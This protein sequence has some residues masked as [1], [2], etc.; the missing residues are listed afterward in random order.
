M[1]Q[2]AVP[3]F[4]T[5]KLTAQLAAAFFAIWHPDRYRAKWRMSNDSAN[6]FGCAQPRGSTQSTRPLRLDH[7]RKTEWRQTPAVNEPYV[8]L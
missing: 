3:L 7:T 1:P 5:E 8:A 2:A 4:S 6:T